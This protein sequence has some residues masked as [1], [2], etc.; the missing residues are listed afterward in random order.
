MWPASVWELSGRTWTCPLSAHLHRNWCQRFLCS[1]AAESRFQ[2]VCGLLEGALQGRPPPHTHMYTGRNNNNGWATT[3]SRWRKKQA[4]P[5]LLSVYVSFHGPTLQET[6]SRNWKTSQSARGD[7]NQDCTEHAGL[8]IRGGA[9]QHQQP[10]RSS[11]TRELWQRNPPNMGLVTD[12]RER[13]PG[14]IRCNDVIQS[15][16]VSLDWLVVWICGK[17]DSY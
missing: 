7:V 10:M 6:S 13:Q 5:V 2:E 9:K 4:H 11:Q 8:W 14:Y 1:D 16:F 17:N 15:Q 3:E 12:N